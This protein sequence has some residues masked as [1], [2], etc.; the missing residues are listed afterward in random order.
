MEPIVT[1]NPVEQTTIYAWPHYFCGKDGVFLVSYETPTGPHADLIAQENQRSAESYFR[2][3]LL[4]PHRF[5]SDANYR[6]T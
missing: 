6:V 4:N 2:Y 1:K 3:V 5:R